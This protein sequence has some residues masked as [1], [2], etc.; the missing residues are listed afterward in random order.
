MQTWTW[1]RPLLFG[2]A[3]IIAAAA[4]CNPGGS[5]STDLG[6]ADMATSDDL[7]G[8]GGGDGGS[9]GVTDM[10]MTLALTG[11]SPA[12]GPTTGNIDVTLSGNGFVTGTTVTIDGQPATVKSVN[13]S[14]V[15]V[16]LP[17]R[18]GVKG[19]VTVVVTNPGGKTV[20]SASIFGYYYGTIAFDPAAKTPVGGAPY[21]VAIAELENNLKADIVATDNSPTGQLLVMSGNGNGTF[22]PVAKYGAGSFA[23]GLKV[24]D[25]N[26][27][28]FNDIVV[29]SATSIPSGISLLA[30]SKTGTF[31]SRTPYTTGDI[32]V[33]VD[34]RDINGDGFL[35]LIVANSGGASNNLSLLLGKSGGT[36]DVPRSLTAGAIPRSV[37]FADVNKDG[38]A[39]IVAANESSATV[40]VLLGDGTGAFAAKKDYPAGSGPYTVIASDFSGDGNMDLLV[41][42]YRDAAVALLTGNGDG[43]FAA[44]KPAS[45]G[46][47]LASSP[48]H[49]ALGDINS[50]GR[51]DVVSAIYADQQIGITVNSGGVLGATTKLTA[52][53]FPRG[54]AVGDVNADGKL[55]IVSANSGDGSISVFLN[56]SQ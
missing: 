34:M 46:T 28:T 30:N 47:Q 16:N 18:P 2:T 3:V 44:P 17:P 15:V 23:F 25:W 26:A 19:A 6:S 14:Q 24:L 35:D 12:Q 20:M 43:T 50:D 21:N 36:F 49:I 31:P 1:T 40:S 48:T 41:C 45:I 53:G 52:L 38:K 29:T 56:K 11:A 8:G 5:D 37:V 51:P 55:D 22:L 54:V 33:S 7:A 42:L 4:S 32:P 9:G 13:Q 27:D 39:D 10:D